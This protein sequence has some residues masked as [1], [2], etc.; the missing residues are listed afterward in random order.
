MK[1]E[2][3]D[4]ADMNRI[5]H[6]KKILALIQDKENPYVAK[7]YYSLDVVDG[8]DLSKYLFMEYYPNKSLDN[9]KNAFKNTMSLNTKIYMLLQVAQGLKFLKE[10]QIVHLDLKPANIL[11]QKNYIAKITDFGESYNS[12]VCDEKFR[13]GRTYPFVAPEVTQSSVNAARQSEKY[14]DKADIFSFGHLISEIIYDDYPVCYKKGNQQSL[15]TK[16]SSGKYQ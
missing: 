8:D 11:I 12:R 16:Y 9:F 4:Q 5:E 10:N 13:P 7:F 6:E 15:A 3:T 1:Q 2:K 14:T